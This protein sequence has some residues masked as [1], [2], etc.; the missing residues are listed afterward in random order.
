VPS[1]AKEG[2]RGWSRGEMVP[3]RRQCKGGW[4]EGGSEREKV[5]E[6]IWS[7]CKVCSGQRT[8]DDAGES[9]ADT[10]DSVLAWATHLRVGLFVPLC[11]LLGRILADQRGRGL[12]LMTPI[13]LRCKGGGRVKR[14]RGGLRRKGPEGERGF[15]EDE[16]TVS[17][18]ILGARIHPP[19]KPRW[20]LP[21]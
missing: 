20:Q 15:S 3:M 1:G 11:H 10:P 16:M 7:E 5:E 14:S 19:R 13:K 6:G 2:Q 21:R 18:E 12:L 8:A 4:I 9:S 17:V